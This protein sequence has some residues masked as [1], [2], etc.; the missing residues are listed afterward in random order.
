[1]FI[2]AGKN[3]PALKGLVYYLAEK[4]NF[5]ERKEFL[6]GIHW[7]FDIE[8]TKTFLKE[9]V[10]KPQTGRPLKIDINQEIEIDENRFD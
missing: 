1:M 3:T 8:K 9:Y 2:L 7:V 10:K 4:Y 6:S 5:G